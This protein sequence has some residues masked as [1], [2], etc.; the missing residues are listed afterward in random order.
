MWHAQTKDNLAARLKHADQPE[1]F[2]ESE[3][4][5]FAALDAYKILSGTFG[6]E[7]VVFLVLTSMS[8][9]ATPE[10]YAEFVDQGGATA[11]VALLSHENNDIVGQVTELLRDMTDDD[12]VEDQARPG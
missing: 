2:M 8:H 6:C 5:L 10:L 11:F 3:V 9:T 12:A 7:F 1:K 4:D